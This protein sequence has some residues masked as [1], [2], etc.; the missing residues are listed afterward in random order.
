MVSLCYQ[1]LCLLLNKS[2]KIQKKYIGFEIWNEKSK[3]W[4]VTFEFNKY[5]KTRHNIKIS[6][7]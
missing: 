3:N 5:N 6:Y 2:H 7:I 4:N 1:L